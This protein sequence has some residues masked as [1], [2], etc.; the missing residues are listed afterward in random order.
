MISRNARLWIGVTLLTMLAVNYGIIGLPLYRK[1]ASLHD[2]ATTVLIKQIKSGN[3]LKTSAEEEY[4]LEIFRREKG[5][6]DRK[7]LILNSAAVT[8]VIIIVSWTGF[9]LLVSKKK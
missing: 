8:I 2:K 6:I 5:S 9:G 7:L 4:I 1:A 3:A